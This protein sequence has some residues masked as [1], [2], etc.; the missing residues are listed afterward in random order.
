MP[1]HLARF[2]PG[3][4]GA[5]CQFR[6]GIS[7]A[8]GLADP[9]D[10]LQVA[11]AAG[12]LLE[13]GLEAVGAVLEFGMA[14]FLLQAFCLEKH[15][16]VEA[17]PPRVVET[18]EKAPV[19]GDLPR[20]EEAGHHGDVLPR[21]LDALG[22]RAHAVGE[23][24]PGV[25]EASDEFFDLAREA[26][27]SRILQQHQHVDVGMRIEL[28][29]PVAADREE[30]ERRRHLQLPP[31]LLQHAVDQAAMLPQHPGAVRGL[32]ELRLQRGALGLH[33]GFQAG[34]GD[35]AVRERRV[36]GQHGVGVSA[37]AEGA[38]RRRGSGPR[39]PYR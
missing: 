34:E 38:C 29:P 39:I 18:G 7:Q 16:G 28:P 19:P 21:L 4:Q 3:N 14:L 2:L 17:F 5:L 6:P 30:R 13:I 11:K 15:L 25:P 24:E 8:A 9:Q 32:A 31:H 12:C 27:G 20:F 23:L 22:D 10:H 1:L 35:A 26:G 33:A 36:R 37:W